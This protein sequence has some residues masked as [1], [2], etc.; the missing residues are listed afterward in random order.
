MIVQSIG[1]TQRKQAELEAAITRAREAERE[2]IERV[3][4]VATLAW[5]FGD[6]QTIGE[7]FPPGQSVRNWVQRNSLGAQ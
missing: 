5:Q 7:I 2:L 4:I 1:E 6:W 3:R